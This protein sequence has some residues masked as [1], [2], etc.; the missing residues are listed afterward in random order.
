MVYSII[1]RTLRSSRYA[2]QLVQQDG[3]SFRD[4]YSMKE[5]LRNILM[6][7]KAQID[8]EVAKKAAM[9]PKR[10]VPCM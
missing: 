8:D 2:K 7:L 4:D 9:K 1:D 5:M 3:E 10:L 6:F